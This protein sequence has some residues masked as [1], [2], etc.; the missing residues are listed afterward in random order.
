LKVSGLETR[1]QGDA[2]RRSNLDARTRWLALYVLCLASLMIVLDV[3]IVGVALPFNSPELVSFKGLDG[4]IRADGSQRV[5]RV[6]EGSRVSFEMEMRGPRVRR[7]DAADGAETGNPPGRGVAREPE[8]H[9]RN[10]R[11]SS[12]CAA[13]AG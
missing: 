3:T 11:L 7:T 6:G 5:E 1:R 9:P 10:R 8:A 4:P 13:G 2:Y 12:L